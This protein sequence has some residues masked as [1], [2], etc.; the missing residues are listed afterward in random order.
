MVAVAPNPPYPLG[1]TGLPSYIMGGSRPGEGRGGRGEKGEE[2][3]QREK[4]PSTFD[5]PALL[6]E[7]NQTSTRRA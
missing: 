2:L 6:G 1:C 5:L 3:E 4:H 7:L